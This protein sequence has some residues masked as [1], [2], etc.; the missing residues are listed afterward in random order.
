VLCVRKSVA[1]RIRSDAHGEN[2]VKTGL[3]YTSRLVMDEEGGG[4]QQEQ[5]VVKTSLT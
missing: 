1:R 4:Q 5:G 3:L 2:I